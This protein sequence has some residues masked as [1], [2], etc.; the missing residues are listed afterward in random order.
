[1]DDLTLLVRP[2]PYS[3]NWTAYTG[4]MD[5]Q[6]TRGIELCPS[7]FQVAAT[8]KGPA[9]ALQVNVGPGWECQ[10]ML[11]NDLVLT[12]YVDRVSPT[13]AK[14]QHTITIVGRSKCEDLVDCS[15]AFSTFQLNTTSALAIAQTLAKPAGIAVKPI[16]DIGS[17]VI[18]QFGVIL[19]ETAFDIIE[20][21]C[22]FAALLAYDD[23]DGNLILTRVGSTS[24]AS[25]F[26]QRQNIQNAT[27]SFAM[28]ERYSAVETVLMS[29][30]TLF[31]APGE[32]GA[33]SADAF[34]NDLVQN[35]SA[36]DKDVPR[37]R[38]LLLI[39]DQNDLAY[40]VAQQR[41]QWEVNRRAGR[42]RIVQ[43]TVDSWRDSAGTL[44]QINSLAPVDLPAFGLN[45]ETLLITEVTFRRGLDG[46]TL[47]DITLMP[48]GA[49]APEPIVLQPFAPEVA[50]ATN[51]GAAGAQ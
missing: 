3:G 51:G 21:V 14:D 31:T 15:A 10:V 19:S 39:A 35:A 4:W 27:A 44:W 41:A 12:G 43:V 18:P 8:A 16:G 29:T 20:R 26:S 11:G 17:T 32:D 30:D 36:T 40:Q 22:R 49:V 50:Q 9:G 38:L 48:P 33:D 24:M 46:G 28:D 7:S 1:M 45:N 37:N 47:A 42:G 23:T 25:G 13:L 2:P 5:Q 6:V 34:A